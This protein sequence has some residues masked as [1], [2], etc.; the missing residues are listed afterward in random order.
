MTKF[1][2]VTTFD[3]RRNTEKKLINA[4][5]IYKVEPWIR[6]NA[7]ITFTNGKELVVNETYEE[8]K[9]LI[10]FTKEVADIMRSNDGD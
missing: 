6:N 9:N 1:I 8:V 10:L 5:A 2:E 7:Q 3:I 4:D